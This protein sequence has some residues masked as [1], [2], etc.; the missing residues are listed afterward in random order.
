MAT[1]LQKLDDLNEALLDCRIVH[2]TCRNEAADDGLALWYVKPKESHGDDMKRLNGAFAV[3]LGINIDK[4]N[5]LDIIVIVK[6]TV[7]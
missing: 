4:P 7:I 5:E 3:G 2:L 6:K 1:E